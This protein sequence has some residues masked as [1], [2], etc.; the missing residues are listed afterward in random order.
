MLNN[1][2]DNWTC[3]GTMAKDLTEAISCENGKVSNHLGNIGD[4][5][6]G[7]P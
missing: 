5:L 3:E 2:K 1:C 4:T 6:T 7:W